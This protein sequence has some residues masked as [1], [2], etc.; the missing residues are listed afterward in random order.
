MRLLPSLALCL[1]VAGC[2]DSSPSDDPPVDPSGAASYRGYAAVEDELYAKF[3]ADGQAFELSDYL[4]TSGDELS[5]LVGRPTGFG[6]SFDPGQ[7]TPNAMNVL[8]WRMMLQAF[9]HDLAA[10]CPHAKG[11]AV[12]LPKAALRAD[13]AGVVQGLCA[14]GA[15]GDDALGAA[16]DYVVGVRAPASSR[17]AYIKMAHGLRTQTGDDAVADLWLAALLHPSFLLAQ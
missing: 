8:V 1:V 5:N 2:G 7:T 10:A 12:Q 13:A 17:A 16:W 4:G 3:V 14:G 15:A 11:A 9:A 6:A